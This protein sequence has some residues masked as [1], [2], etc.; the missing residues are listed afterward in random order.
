MHTSDTAP[1][2]ELPQSFVAKLAQ[3]FPNATPLR[4]PV[5][6]THVNLGGGQF[7][8]STTIEFVTNKEVLFSSAL[9]LQFADNL[10]IKKPDDLLDVDVSVVAVQYNYGKTAVAARFLKDVPDWIVKP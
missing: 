4:I 9:P 8:E 1:P 6:L 3:F 7:S 10:R 2:R 5:S